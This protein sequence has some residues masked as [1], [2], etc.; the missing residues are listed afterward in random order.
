MWQN[1]WDAFKILRGNSIAQNTYIRKQK[2]SQ[3]NAPNSHHYK[4]KKQN[5]NTQ[6]KQK[7]EN[8]KKVNFKRTKINKA[9]RH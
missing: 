5:N 3:T 2:R 7:K 6:I 1:L 8:R 4:L 9:E